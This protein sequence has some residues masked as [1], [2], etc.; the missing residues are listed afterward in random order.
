M[1]LRLGQIVWSRWC[2]CCALLFFGTPLLLSGQSSSSRVSS[3]EKT[4]LVLQS[5]AP[6]LVLIDG[7]E[8]ARLNADG[9]ARVLLSHGEKHIEA[10]GEHPEDRWET[11][12]LIEP[13]VKRVVAIGMRRTIA[14]RKKRE[15]TLAQQAQD[16]ED[17]KV[18]LDT[19][20]KSLF[21]AASYVSIPPGIFERVGENSGAV[22]E[23]A[24]T[25]LISMGRH[26]VTQAQWESIMRSN[27][28]DRKGAFHPVESVSWFDAKAFL[29]SLN[30]MDS[31]DFLYRLPTEAEWEY[32][33]RANADKEQSL[34]DAGWYVD[35]AGESTHRVG[36]KTPNGWG[37]FD[38]RGN[39][40]EWVEDWYGLYDKKADLDPLAV[41]EGR[42]RIIRGGS[43]WSPAEFST[44]SY[45]GNLAPD[46]KA[47]I[48]GFRV[49]REEPS[50]VQPD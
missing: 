16:E 14:A 39:V 22:H 3:I 11:S 10:I 47:T 23:V 25:K 38:M 37:L 6:C 5:D 20:R 34:E 44:C 48:L 9:I 26:E 50:P 30:A 42:A 29:D 8:V 31:S 49:V 18:L 33:C 40:W 13:G 7:V 15:K 41:E 1:T 28:S 35:N 4:E 27:P 12:I 46:Y 21:D 43:W 45:R 36:Q 19:A 24:I 2:V 32:A 17:Q